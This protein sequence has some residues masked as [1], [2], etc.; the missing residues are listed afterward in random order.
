MSTPAFQPH[1]HSHCVHDALATAER[2][3]AESGARLTP[4]RRRVLE[5]VWNSHKPLGAYEL[6]DRLTAEG[7]KPAPPTVYRALEFLLEQKLVHRIASRNAFVGCSHPGAAHAGYFLLCETCGNAEEIA[8]SQALGEAVGR[9][10]DS[11]DFQVLSQTLEL[12]GLC[13]RC[14]A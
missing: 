8:D 4:L 1:D 10:A 11:A 2:L 3:C 9:A 14:R 7:H 6:L 13:R 12:T 5:L